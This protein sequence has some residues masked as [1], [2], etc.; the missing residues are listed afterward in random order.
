[1]SDLS[2]IDENGKTKMVNITEKEKTTRKA[3][4]YGK[5]TLKPETLKM[6]KNGDIEK[7]TVLETARIAGIMAVKDTP[8][9]IPLCHQLQISGIDIDFTFEDEKSIGITV[10]I[11]LKG[12]TGAEMEALTGASTA[13]LTI[14]DMCK[15]VDKEMVIGEIKLLEKSGGKSGHFKREEENNAGNSESSLPE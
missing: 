11:S 4:A 6:I 13:A 9:I 2:H 8:S 15:A 3:I 7:G 10:T 5:I 14:Y 12:K 1:M